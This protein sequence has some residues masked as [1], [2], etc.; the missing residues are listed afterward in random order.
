[1][2]SSGHVLVENSSGLVV[3]AE[4]IEANGRAERLV[5]EALFTWRAAPLFGADKNYAAPDI[6]VA[7]STGS[8]TMQ[9]ASPSE[10]GD[11]A[12]GNPRRE[13]PYASRLFFAS[14]SMQTG[15]LLR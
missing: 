3:V 1:M 4:L 5:D 15:A 6:F 11:W 14:V 9:S 12:L 8:E 7:I 13:V 2:P 10:G